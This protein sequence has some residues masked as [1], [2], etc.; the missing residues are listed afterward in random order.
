MAFAIGALL[1]WICGKGAPEATTTRDLSRKLWCAR[2]GTVDASCSICGS[3]KGIS[4]EVLE[5]FAAVEEYR[6]WLA[7]DRACWLAL[8][9]KRGPV[10]ARRQA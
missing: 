10:E 1:G 9:W 6:E 5:R 3:D 8:A 7:V 4:P 2:C